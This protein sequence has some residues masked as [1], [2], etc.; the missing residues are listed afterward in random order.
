[1]TDDTTTD[2]IDWATRAER[3]YAAVYRRY[4]YAPRREGITPVDAQAAIDT[5][6]DADLDLATAAYFADLKTD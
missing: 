3:A 4:N 2:A 6:E 1:M 5:I